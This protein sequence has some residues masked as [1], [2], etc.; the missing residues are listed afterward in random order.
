MAAAAGIVVAQDYA[1]PDSDNRTIRE[2]LTVLQEVSVW[3]AGVLLHMT[4]AYGSGF[5]SHS[6]YTAFS[7]FNIRHHLRLVQFEFEQTNQLHRW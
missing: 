6:C 1:A 3:L 5:A 2:R 7:R 4:W